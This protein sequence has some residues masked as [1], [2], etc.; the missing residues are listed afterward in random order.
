MNNGAK[1]GASLVLCGV[2]FHLFGIVDFERPFLV[3]SLNTVLLAS[4]I[5]FSIKEF[6][7]LHSGGFISFAKC[8]KV[9]ISVGVFSA[10]IFGFWK[11]LLINYI[12]SDYADLALQKQQQMLLEFE[13]QYPGVMP[14]VDEMLDTIDEEGVKQYRPLNI[15][16]NEIVSKTLGSFILSLLFVFFL[17][18]ENNNLMV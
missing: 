7:D 1:L 15:L 6:R 12:D 10:I 17:K 4:F 14:N 9:G 13:V 8:I 5:F 3:L 18:K 16:M 11:V 2:L